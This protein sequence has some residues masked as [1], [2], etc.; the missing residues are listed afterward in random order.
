MLCVDITF[1]FSTAG[2]STSSGIGEAESCKDM[3]FL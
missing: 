2:R 1:D 3:N